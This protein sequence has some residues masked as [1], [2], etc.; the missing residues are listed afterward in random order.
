MI[1]IKI[2]YIGGGSRAWAPELMSDLALSPHLSGEIALYDIDHAAAA[3]N[4]NVGNAIFGHARARSRFDVNA[5]ESVDDALDGADFVVLSI[6]PG[7]IT[8]RYADLVIPAKYGIPQTVGDTTGPGGI[9]R[10]LRVV[11]IYEEFAH[12]IM[13]RCPDAWVINYTNPMTICTATLHRVEPRIRA[14]GCCHEVFGTQERLAELVAGW[15]EVPAP[16]RREITL[17]IGGVNHFTF[18][19][20]ARWNGN[21]LFPRLRALAETPEMLEDATR[22]AGDRKTHEQWFESDGLIALDFLRRFGVLGA[23]GD[24]HL[25]EFVP[26]YLQSEKDVH[27]WGVVLTPYEWRVKRLSTFSRRDPDAPLEPSGE[28]G[29]DQIHALLGLGDLTTNVNIP[30]VGQLSGL[31]EGAVVETYAQFSRNNLRPIVS[32]PLPSLLASHVRHISA[33]QELTL[34]AALTRDRDLAFQALISDPLVRIPTDRA[35]AMFDEML[36]HVGQ[37]LPGWTSL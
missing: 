8:M 29:V 16:H 9:L 28:E 2:A 3:A 12:R 34:D 10:A 19:T 1:S 13:A 24:R 35:S 30:N 33:V 5:V 11:P 18:A 27:R 31:P 22:R 21:D 32:R 20:D 15:F 7:P 17:D 37:W 14:F 6:E 4:V 26:W 36:S 25:A 23:A